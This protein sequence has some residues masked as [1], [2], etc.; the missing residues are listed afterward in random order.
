MRF[1]VLDFFFFFK[2]FGTLLL[3][4]VLRLYGVCAG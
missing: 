2:F 3:L 4:S 1:L